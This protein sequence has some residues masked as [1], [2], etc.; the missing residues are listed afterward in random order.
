MQ[1]GRG[2]DPSKK[3]TNKQTRKENKALYFAGVCLGYR[4]GGL[5]REGGVVCFILN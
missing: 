4:K 3:D 1:E 2:G 5:K